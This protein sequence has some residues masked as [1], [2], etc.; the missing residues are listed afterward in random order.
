MP[1]E[2]DDEGELVE[3]EEEEKTEMVKSS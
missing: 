2:Y 1:P 3:G